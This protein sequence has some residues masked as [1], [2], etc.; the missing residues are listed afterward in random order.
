[1]I[2]EFIAHDSRLRFGDLNHRL[3]AD[4]NVPCPTGLFGRYQAESGM[5]RDGRS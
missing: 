3:V 2:G 1:M 5:F 4:L